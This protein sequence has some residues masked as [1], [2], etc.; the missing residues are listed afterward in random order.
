MISEQNLADAPP[1][2]AAGAPSNQFHRYLHAT[3]F[4]GLWM[5]IGWIFRPDANSYLLIGVPLTVVFQIFVRRKPLVTLWVRDPANF[6]LSNPRL[7]VGVVLA[8]GFAV[9]PSVMLVHSF[10]SGS[11][12]SH[13]PETLWTFC[14]VVGAFGAGFSFGQFTKQTWKSLGLCLSTAGVIGCGIMASVF[15]IK[16]L[17]HEA[18][19]SLSFSQVKAGVASL[20]IYV[21]IC[22]VLEEVSFRGAIDAHVHQPGDRYPWLSA[23]FVSCLW[24]WWH[25]PIL[26]ERRIS[27]LIALAILMPLMHSATGIFLSFG[28]RRSGNLAVP[29]IVH[30]LIDAVRNML[31]K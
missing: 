10:T 2:M 25:L 20:L 4:V 15:L 27:G 9:L 29:A 24:G 1:V 16:V 21:P 17:T 30:A 5:A 12:R 7:A 23:L 11:W 13:V 31:L 26:G 14:A 28:W 3:A 22:F 19:L 18:A 8:V 6:R